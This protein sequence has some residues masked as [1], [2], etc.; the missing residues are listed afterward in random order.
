L[1]FTS[2]LCNYI[3][4]LLVHSNFHCCLIH[5]GTSWYAAVFIVVNTA[6]GTGFLNLPSAYHRSGGIA[7]GLTLQFVS[8]LHTSFYVHILQVLLLKLNHV[9]WSQSVTKLMN[10]CSTR[11]WCWCSK[12]C[13]T[14]RHDTCDL[15]SLDSMLF[16]QQVPAT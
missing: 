6:I 9:S 8:F 3:T 14:A 7:V 13:T 2:V 12:Y 15:L 5:L 11:S 1:L 4:T 16:G 10:A